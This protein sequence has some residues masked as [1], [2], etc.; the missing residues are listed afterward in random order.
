[1]SSA[2]AA[3]V[4]HSR[5]STDGSPCLCSPIKWST[6]EYN[7]WWQRTCTK[8]ARSGIQIL[9]IWKVSFCSQLQPFLA[10]IARAPGFLFS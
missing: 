6:A 10:G 7:W 5:E 1:M 9:A 8:Q 3:Q 2:R 4:S